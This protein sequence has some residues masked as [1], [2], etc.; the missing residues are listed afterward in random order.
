MS[1]FDWIGQVEALSPAA[2]TRRVQALPANNDG[3]QPLQWATFAPREN[4]NSID[5]T[6]MMTTDYRPVADRREWNA[7]GR[8]VPPVL[9]T[10]RKIEM[11]PIESYDKIEEREQQ[12][13]AEGAFGNADIIIR[14]MGLRIPDRADRL[15][16]ANL[17]RLEMDFHNA[18]ALGT[19]TQRNAQNGATYAFSFGFS[20]SRYV[21][22]GTAWNDAGVNAYDLFLASI[23]SAE[24]LIGAVGGAKMRQ[25]TL[26]AILAAAP[27]IGAGTIRMT[28][29][30][31]EQDI[32]DRRGSGF[33]IVVD[34]RSV[35][36]FDDGG[37]AYTRTKVWPAQ[38]VGFIPDDG[39]IGRTPFAPVRRAM[40]LAAQVPGAGIDVRDNTVYHYAGNGGKELNMECQLNAFPVP[41]ESRLYVVNAGV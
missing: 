21:T 33:N 34:E 19:F 32:Q 27:T 22:A 17:R 1:T 24:D 7:P 10:T 6:D 31:L 37:T 39:L 2:L 35:D 13:L 26:N 36:V 25:A 14:E 23:A 41:D 3:R 15:A 28:F 8:Y 5:V 38:R 4:V 18:W 29:R 9:P 40:E 16:F 30:Q 20:S 12:K 11:V